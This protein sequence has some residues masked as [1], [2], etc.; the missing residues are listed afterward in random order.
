MDP[1]Y[2]IRLQLKDGDSEG[3]LIQS[4]GVIA[5]V[6]SD[7]YRRCGMTLLHIIAVMREYNLDADIAKGETELD[8]FWPRQSFFFVCT[9]ATP[10]LANGYE[11]Q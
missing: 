4:H 7:T 9:K 5:F 11:P 3:M 1:P 6:Y 10:M 8:A 2:G